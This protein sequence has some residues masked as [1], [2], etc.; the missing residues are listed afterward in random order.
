[1]FRCSTTPHKYEHLGACCVDSAKCSHFLRF[2]PTE[3]PSIP[4]PSF[5]N[6]MRVFGRVIPTETIPT[7]RVYALSRIFSVLSS[8]SSFD[9]QTELIFLYVAYAAS[10]SSDGKWKTKEKNRSGRSS[11]SCVSSRGQFFA[12]ADPIL[13]QFD[14]PQLSLAIEP[15]N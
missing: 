3:R 12:E 7:N 5:Q 8:V 10:F 14:S 13:G 9:F 6:D 2:S 1:M 4:S 15:P 11:V